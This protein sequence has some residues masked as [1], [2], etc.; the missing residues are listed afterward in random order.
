[1]VEVPGVAGRT[2]GLRLGDRKAPELGAVR[3]PGDHQPGCA[4]TADER[5]VDRTDRRR[6]GQRLV[7]VGERRAGHAREQVLQE[8]RHTPERSLGEV[9]RRCVV[10]RSVEPAQHDRVDRIVVALDAFDGGVEEL[11]R[12]H[13][14]RG[15]E[16]GLLGGVHPS[17]VIGK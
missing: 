2:V 16:R 7:A 3:A 12:R 15:D 1:V 6:G 14:A 9:S 4:L 11:H 13:L 5:G 17:C 10:A 8:E